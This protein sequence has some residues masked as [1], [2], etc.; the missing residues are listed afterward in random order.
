MDIEG[1]HLE[2]YLIAWIVHEYIGFQVQP[3]PSYI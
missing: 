1:F 3:N 2:K